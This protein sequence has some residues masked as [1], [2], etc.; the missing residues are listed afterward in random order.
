MKFVLRLV[1]LG[2]LLSLP[3][4][5]PA[6]A[7]Y[8]YMDT[9]GDGVYS[10]ADVLNPNGTATT[11]DV[12]LNTNHNRDG[13]LATCDTGDGDLG[14][15]NSYAVNMHTPAGTVAYTNFVNQQP[16]FTILCV[17]SPSVDFL[18][19]ATEMTSCRATGSPTAAGLKKL[20]TVTVT[21]VTGAPSLQFM[22]LGT[23]G[24]NATS[25]GTPCS[26]HDFDNTYK[27]GSDFLDSDG[28]G[29]APGGN[30]TPILTAPTTAT[31]TE[32]QP[33]T[34]TANATDSDAAD[35]LTI[36]ATGQPASLTLTTTP[37]SSPN[38]ATL[39]GTLGVNDQG[40][41]TI[42]WSVSDGVNAPITANTVLTVNNVDRNPVVT[43][44]ATASGTVGTL[45]TVTATASDPDGD[46]IADLTASPLP[47]GATFTANASNSEGTLSWTPAL[48][49]QGEYDIT[50][51]ASNT[52]IGFS[53]THI[54][55]VANGTDQAPIVTAPATQ[56]AAETVLLSFTVTASDPDGDPITSLTASPLPTGATFTAD[57]SNTSGTFN[58][59]PAVGQVGT[60][61]IS[62]TALNA[63]SGSAG[64]TIAVSAQGA[65]Q[66][67]V[68]TAP[69][70]ENGTVGTLLT[71][72]VAATDPDGEA[73]TSLTAAPLPTG[74]SLTANV[75]NT[76]GTFDWTPT[77][78]QTGTFDVTF[79]ASNAL[80]GSATTHITIA[81]QAVDQAPVVT[82][83]ANESGTEGTL[84]T[85][86]VTA[87]DPDA[88][89][90]T[91][92][93][94]APL[95]TGATFTADAGNTSGTFNWTPSVGQSGTYD[96][97]FTASNALSGSATTHITI[98]AQGVDQAPIVTAPANESGTEGTLLTFTVT[99]SDPDGDAITSLTGAPL[100]TGATFTANASNTSGTFSWTPSVGQSGTYDVTFTA[101]NALSGSATT[102]ITI[103]APAA[104][105][106]PVVTAP[107]TES[108]TEGVL[109]T[110]TVSVSDPDG[111]PITSFTAAPLPAGATFTANAANTSGTFNWTPSAGQA[112]NYDV[113]LTAS[114]ALSGSATTHIAI[115]EAGN[116]P[117]VV[118]APATMTVNE[119]Q[120][121]TFAVTATDADGNHVTLTAAGVPSG[122]SFVDNGDN[123]GTFTWTP[124]STQAGTYTVTF[125]GNDGHGGTDDAATVITVNDVGGG[126]AGEASAKLIGNFNPHRRFLCFH[127]EPVN[128]SFDVHDVD[129]TSITLAFGGGTIHAVEGVTHLDTDCDDD[130][131]CEECDGD[132][133]PTDGTGDCPAKLHACFLMSDIVTLFG[134]QSI[135]DNLA[136]ATLSGSLSGGGTFTA[137]MSDF[138]VA[139]DQGKKGLHS[140]ARPNPLNPTTRLSFTLSQPG[141]VRVDLFDARG[142]LVKTLLNESRPVGENVVAW[143][144]SDSRGGHVSSGVYFFRIQ[145]VEAQEVVRVTV[146]K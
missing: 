111:D 56:S 74:A 46:L 13:S 146:L 65:D 132:E 121:L 29:P 131:E 9:N 39:S 138:R 92:L 107:A 139:G 119:G 118:T 60:Y 122:A 63:L 72:T 16:D 4:V 1:A 124:G 126:G 18:S 97:T 128:G 125:T 120:L 98:V 67:P 77:A 117:P 36:G 33:L 80:S 66:A 2:A 106:A 129:L 76:S 137:T 24:A 10:S 5:A 28:A 19:N 8:L 44:P 90:I 143:D 31:G 114:N 83:P 55:I 140:N 127:V 109:L 52:M 37:G 59:T 105:Q 95:P 69:A 112:G 94:A 54:T 130:E 48:G 102:H 21:G 75:T 26:G 15:W 88:D 49:Q 3:F 144:G 11:V 61:N 6:S 110:F 38:S 100:P 47:T 85:F 86:T 136:N 87:S 123:T 99:A 7:Q 113:T 64:T 43:A 91:S 134:D 103:A 133:P 135:P 84:L 45:L 25:F 108:G 62:F 81:G 40:D 89:A 73:I 58:W 141:K 41:H 34:I 14:T 93:T 22:A 70:T 71:F 115:A 23:L 82:A 145:S 32:G 17:L 35:V 104:D 20:F 68:V 53:T 51:T 27:L 30:A 78:A 142:K 79:T 96:V 50:F 116:N 12:W 42:V 101:S 57:A